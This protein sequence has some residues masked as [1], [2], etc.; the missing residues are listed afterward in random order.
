MSIGRTI[1]RVAVDAAT[2]QWA[3]GKTMARTTLGAGRFI[4][5]VGFHIE[6]GKDG[7]LDAV[8]Y[9]LGTTRIEI[10][11]QREGGTIVPHWFLGEE[12]SFH[13]VTSGPPATTMG[14]CLQQAALT[15]AAGLGARWPDG[16]RSKLAVRGYISYLFRA[17]YT[18]PVQLTTHSR[19]TDV[20]LACLVAHSAA[21]VAADDLVDRAK[22][23]A[24]VDLHEV[25]LQF[26]AADEQEWG[27]GDTATVTPFRC[28]HPAEV[29]A[30]YLR[31]LWRP[32]ALHAAALADWPS[33]QAWAAD[34]A[35]E[36]ES[37]GPRLS[38]R[39]LR[40]EGGA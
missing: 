26:C 6:I 39:G 12:L 21:C 24:P 34:Y 35:A 20:L 30:D 31:G 17:G 15:A 10:K 3:N 18:A 11:H 16:E 13:P 27:K 36:P 19:M 29:D 9:E 2:L 23:P 37:G 22:H 7:E 4:P 33:I 1:P 14:G 25:A 38:S 32:E 8:L 28:A 5:L 40:G